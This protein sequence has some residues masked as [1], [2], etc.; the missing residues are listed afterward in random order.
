MGGKACGLGV[1]RIRHCPR[2]RLR[3]MPSSGDA[4][5]HKPS[6]VMACHVKAVMLRSD[7]QDPDIVL[8]KMASTHQMCKAHL[9]T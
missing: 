6:F 7:G 2:W 4:P 3:A 8:K 5:I 1:M 9:K